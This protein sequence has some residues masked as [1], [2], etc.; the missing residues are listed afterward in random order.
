MSDS[1][2]HLDLVMDAETGS[3]TLT[4]GYCPSQG[5]DNEWYFE[6][7]DEAMEA[8]RAH[9]DWHKRKVTDGL[10]ADSR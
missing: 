10:Q 1:N 4:C 8:T 3:W 2:K 7:V 6:D 9:L 5:L